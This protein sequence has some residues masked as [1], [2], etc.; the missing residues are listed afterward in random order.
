[1]SLTIEFYYSI[2]LNQIMLVTHAFLTNKCQY[3]G[4]GLNSKENV[5]HFGRT[6]L[7]SCNIH[8][9]PKCT[10]CLA[11]Y[12][13]SLDICLRSDY[14]YASIGR[15]YKFTHVVH[16]AFMIVNSCNVILWQDMNSA[17]ININGCIIFVKRVIDSQLFMV[18]YV[19]DIEKFTYKYLIEKTNTYI[20]RLPRD[21]TN[22]ILHYIC[23]S[24]HQ[25]KLNSFK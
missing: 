20:S 2:I 16:T 1:M 7:C 4:C 18:S 11:H 17:I 14:Q 5:M 21:I 12:G 8:Y 15:H 13:D 22:I 24:P 19:N 10:V 9:L 3:P 6:C 25:N 23:M